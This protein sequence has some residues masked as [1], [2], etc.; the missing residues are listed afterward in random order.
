MNKRFFILG[1]VALNLSF[2][3]CTFYRVTSDIRKNVGKLSQSFD[4][5][6]TKIK[7][8]LTEKRT[9]I[10]DIKQDNS[11]ANNLPY[12]K[13]EGIIT[14][15]EN[16]DKQYEENN[17]LLKSSKDEL[18]D[19]IKDKKKIR[20]NEPE[21]KKSEALIKKIKKVNSKQNDI[22][23]EYSDKSQRFNKAL[24]DS[25]IIKIDVKSTKGEAVS[26]KSKAEKTITERK[27]ALAK[28][29]AELNSKRHL[30]QESKAKDIDTIIT[31]LGNILNEIELIIP[32]IDEIIKMISTNYKD[33]EFIYLGPG[34]TN[35]AKEEVQKNILKFE[36]LIEKYNKEISK[37]DKYK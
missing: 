14:E 21:W 27:D 22:L 18:F 17:I 20:S 7:N 15:L 31:N 3:S 32:N 1:L 10:T 16:I 4:D 19:I 6:S 13:L 5:Y 11:S 12:H 37:L 30:L 23:K 29:K 36:A 33:R 9:I 24:K 34:N 28:A 26:F 25:K 35:I 8:D 2:V